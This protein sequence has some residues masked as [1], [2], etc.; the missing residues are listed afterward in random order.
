MSLNGIII[1]NISGEV[2]DKLMVVG[3]DNTLNDV[4]VIDLSG[5][6]LT[7]RKPANFTAEFG[8][9]GLFFKGYPT[10]CGGFPWNR[11]CYKYDHLVIINFNLL[12]FYP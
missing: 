9:T 1:V 11:L 10:A 7:C 5:Q 3:G 12:S 8:A 2:F 6:T 4:E